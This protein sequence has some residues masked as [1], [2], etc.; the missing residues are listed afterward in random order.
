MAWA[1]AILLDRDGFVGVDKPPGLASTGRT[2][3]DPECLQ[4]RL[5]RWAGRMVW[6]VH[7]LDTDTSGAILFARRKALVAEGARRLRA[8]SGRK[9]YLAVCH[10]EPDFAERTIRL[11]IGAATGSGGR[12]AVARTGRDARTAVR[13]LAR[14]GGFSLLELRLLTGRTHQARIHLAHIGH[15]L[16]GERSY[17]DAPCELH[18]RHALHASRLVLGGPEPLVIEAP[19]APDLA[20]LVDRLGLSAGVL[21]VRSSNS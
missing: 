6:A 9:L 8:R 12:L 2:L 16:V 3:D 10:G 18:P 13:V 19:L 1:P 7:Q 11:P 15:P 17:R 21:P 14:S 4:W 5:C 20:R